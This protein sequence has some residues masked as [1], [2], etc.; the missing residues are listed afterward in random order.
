MSDEQMTPK[1][2]VGDRVTLSGVVSRGTVR[3]VFVDVGDHI[4][5]YFRN[6]DVDIS[7][8][9]QSTTY[10]DQA[11][12]AALQSLVTPSSFQTVLSAFSLDGKTVF[13]AYDQFA[14]HAFDLAEALDAERKKRD[15]W[16]E[17]EGGI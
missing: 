1:F 5:A 4:N 9:E 17:K 8:S 11:A 13:D 7:I 2:K 15:A 6:E 14:K 16:L 12:I 3:G 10:R